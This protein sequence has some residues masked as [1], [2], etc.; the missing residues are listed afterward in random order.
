MQKPII[1]RNESQGIGVLHQTSVS[2]TAPIHTHADFYEVFLVLNGKALHMINDQAE[3]LTAG[4]LV[5]IRPSDIHCYDFY[6]EFDFNF[7]N[8]SLSIHEFKTITDLFQSPALDSLLERSTPPS[9]LLDAKALITTRQQFE[10]IKVLVEKQQFPLAI[11]TMKVMLCNIFLHYFVRGL[12]LS[13]ASSGIPRWLAD[14]IAKMHQTENISLGLERMISLS[15]YTQEYLTRSCKKY[16]DLTPTQFINR[17]R[18]NLSARLLTSTQSSIIEIS[19]QCGFQNLSHFYHLFKKAYGISPKQYR[20]Q[21]PIDH[22]TD[23]APG[24]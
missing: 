11:L 1:Y 17:I 3:L 7:Y 22:G 6:H 2:Q 21:N 20:E 18:L 14:L 24:V 4:S 23:S 5:L 9:V 16:L 13:E 19:E 10:Q 8:I 12:P 15:G